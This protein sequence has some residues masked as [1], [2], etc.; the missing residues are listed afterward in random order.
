MALAIPSFIDELENS[1]RHMKPS[2]MSGRDSEPGLKTH[3]M[4][5]GP[6]PRS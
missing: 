5:T 2:R 4:W 3:V 6:A 1:V